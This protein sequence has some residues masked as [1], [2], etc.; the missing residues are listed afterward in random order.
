MRPTARY[1]FAYVR[2]SERPTVPA[3]PG[4][5]P[6]QVPRAKA[7]PYCQAEG[8]VKAVSGPETCGFCDGVGFVQTISRSGEFP[9]VG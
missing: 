5:P 6:V 9:R 8:F 3:P 2:P 4:Y 7:C 1:S